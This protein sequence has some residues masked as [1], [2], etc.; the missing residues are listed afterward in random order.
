[1]NFEFL[2]QHRFI[3]FTELAVVVMFGVLSVLGS[4]GGGDDVVVDEPSTDFLYVLSG[5][6]GGTEPLTVSATLGEDTVSVTITPTL[7][8]TYEST[9]DTYTVNTNCQA[10]DP[11]VPCNIVAET[12]AT[13]GFGTITGTI[14]ATWRWVGDND[15]TQGQFVVT[16]TEIADTVTVE[17]ISTPVAGVSLTNGNDT[18]E[19]TWEQFDTLWEEPANP[20]WQRIASFAYNVRGL[21]FEQITLLGEAYLTI[22]DYRT[23]LEANSAFQGVCSTPLP[24]GSNWNNLVDVIWDDVGNDGMI[25]SNETITFVMN[26][27]WID[28]P[29]E[30]IDTLLSGTMTIFNLDPYWQS[31]PAFTTLSAEETQ[32]G[33]IIPDS[34]Y[35]LDGGFCFLMVNQ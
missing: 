2:K 35:V 23:L 31:C 30:N 17:V 11:V 29:L 10:F 6:R 13:L 20:L 16:S 33:A 24:V 3:R 4:G 26:E 14:T 22:E 15:P 32:N 28:D 5:P 27:C 19:L 7:E 34:G 12:S 21:L 18:D 9:T 25:N 1:M 8:G